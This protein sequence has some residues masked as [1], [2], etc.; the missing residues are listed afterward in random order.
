[1]NVVS[2]VPGP[3]DFAH[4]AIPLA[5]TS[6]A[7]PHTNNPTTAPPRWPLLLPATA[8]TLTPPSVALERHAHEPHR[9]GADASAEEHG[10]DGLDPAHVEGARDHE[11]GNDA[12]HDPSSPAPLLPGHR[13]H[14][15]TLAVNLAS[16]H[17][18]RLGRM[19]FG[20]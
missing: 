3:A 11:Q 6:R 15:I 13:R 4:V 18:S 14:G 19:C 7:A 2:L 20:S 12:P 9:D 17:P 10:E 16:H 1:M 8:G 5:I